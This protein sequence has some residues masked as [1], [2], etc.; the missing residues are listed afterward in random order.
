MHFVKAKGI[1]S[2]KNGANLYRGCTHGCIYC[3][4]RSNC[5]QM[6]HEFTDIEVK[7]NA[8]ELLEEELLKKRNKVMVG[9]GAMTDPYLHLENK[10]QYTRR[11]LEVIE[12]QGHGV[13]VLT[14][15]TMVLRDLDLLVKIN[16]KAKAIVQMT[17]TTFDDELCK[18][19]EPNVSTSKE[20]LDC[21]KKFNE[22][23]I[24]TVV[25]F[26]P[27]LPFINDSLENL[28]GILNYCLEANVK[29]IMY[30]GMGVTM[31][32]GNREYFYKKLD[33]HFPGLKEKY[34]KTY[35]L[36]YMISVPNSKQLHEYFIKFCDKHNII[37]K[38]EE[39]FNYL[40]ELEIEK[41]YEQISLF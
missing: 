39:V 38:P 10:L 16:K 32:D 23:G 34:I 31:R 40:G 15:S 25:W 19:L 36:N 6:N 37:Y 41:G 5:Y 8:I 30:F 17:L 29:Y 4:S 11:M 2:A 28:K 20:R 24:K 22:A 12:K 21:L 9:T 35:G 3:D 13:S 18:I 27:I 1:L 33:E 14:K 7:E 26:G